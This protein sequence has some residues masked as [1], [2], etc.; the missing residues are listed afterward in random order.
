[1][2]YEIAPGKN[3]F[4]QTLNDY[5]QLGGLFGSDTLYDS[6]TSD[7]SRLN[8]YPLLR[9]IPLLSAIDLC[10]LS[11]RRSVSIFAFNI[12]GLGVLGD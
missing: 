9:V 1:M 7:K 11:G 5:N 12:G 4:N 8:A 3:S 6:D 2:G 10:S